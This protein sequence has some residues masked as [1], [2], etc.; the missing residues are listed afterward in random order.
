MGRQGFGRGGLQGERKASCFSSLVHQPSH[1]QHRWKRREMGAG[2]YTPWMRWHTMSSPGIT[3][4]CQSARLHRKEA[5]HWGHVKCFCFLIWRWSSSRWGFT[6]SS[7]V[8]GNEGQ[9]HPR[10][11][12]SPVPF[13]AH[14]P[15]PHCLQ[16]AV[17]SPAL[18][19]HCK[20]LKWG[21]TNCTALQHQALK[22]ETKGPQ[23]HGAF[24]SALLQH[25]HQHGG[26]RCPSRPACCGDAASHHDG[27]QVLHSSASQ[28]LELHSESVNLGT[29]D[30][31]LCSAVAFCTA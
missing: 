10:A 16:R 28:H 20:P 26:M 19:I 31:R 1:L 17:R 18:T 4:L 5:P 6:P 9:A 15:T 8:D 12:C 23:S 13:S 7:T 30:A 11:L 24:R 14:R 2:C 27:P 25:H 22:A 29:T 3:S 21:C